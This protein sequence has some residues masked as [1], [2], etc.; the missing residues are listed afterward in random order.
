MIVIVSKRSIMS[1]EPQFAL[2]GNI[3]QNRKWMVGSHLL[4][5]V[6]NVSPL[7]SKASSGKLELLTALILS[8]HIIKTFPSSGDNVM[9]CSL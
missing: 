6:V 7:T 3:S 1:R 5:S 8:Y 9:Y 4:E 2:F